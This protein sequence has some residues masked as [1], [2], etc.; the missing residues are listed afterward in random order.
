MKLGSITGKLSISSGDSKVEPLGFAFL[1]VSRF[2]LFGNV[3][4][5][6]IV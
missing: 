3:I 2:F 6:R 1:A 5:L 4:F